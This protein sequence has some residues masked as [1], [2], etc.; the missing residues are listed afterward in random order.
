[1]KNKTTHFWMHLAGVLYG[2]LLSAQLQA[3]DILALRLNV[4]FY[5]TP[6]A[7][8]LDEISEKGRFQWSYN[9]NILEKDRRVTFASQQQTVREIL[10]E[11]LGGE[12][13]FKQSGE[14]LI[15]KKVKKPE[16]R[17]SGYLSDKKTGKKLPNATIYDRQTLKSTTTDEH[18][19]YELPVTPRSE[20]VV[21]TLDYKD[22]VLQVTS[23]SPRFLKIEMLPDSSGTGDTPKSLRNTVKEDFAKMQRDFT[24]LFNLSKQE[25]NERNTNNDSLRRSF[26]LSFMPHLGTNHRMS[27]SVEND[28][29]INI[30]VGYSKGNRLVEVGGIGNITRENI[31]GVQ[32]GGVFNAVG[33]QV[34]GVQIGGTFNAVDGH[35]DGVQIG[36]TFNVVDGHVDGVQIGGTLNAVDGNVTGVQIGGVLN[37]V[38][39]NVDGVQI[40]G[41]VNVVEGNALGVQIA[42]CHNQADTAAL[43]ISGI[44]NISQYQKGPQV[45]GILNITEQADNAIQ[46]GGIL[47]IS[48]RGQTPTQVG[49][50]GNIADTTTGTQVA[51]IFNRANYVKGVQVG[52]INSARTI[53]GVQVGLLNF[54]RYGGYCTLEA[55]TNEIHWANVALKTGTHRFYTIFTAGYS[56]ETN[57]A[58]KE[59]LWSYGAGIGTYLRAQKRFGVSFDL[60]HRHLS[61]G[62]YSDDLREW[63]QLAVGFNWRLGKHFHLAAGPS[64]NLLITRDQNF[65]NE[66]IPA[67]YPQGNPTNSDLL[68]FWAGG[69]VSV[70]YRF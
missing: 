54:S 13:T 44:S 38:D 3:H 24:K 50:I 34:N 2:T 26:Q 37:A 56:P 42:G 7:T 59:T 22:T 1:M 25:I 16:Q 67:G 18:G 52:L 45:G 14:Y 4:S 63:E 55:S 30:L 69:T 62:R 60:I 19:Y 17:V 33:G 12:Y 53:N 28:I 40:G 21:A 39:G 31:E 61:Q 46:V 10:H 29:S 8:A 41:V 64:A 5:Q 27:G 65:K 51:G 47:N 35:V 57:T 68:R 11:I 49:G 9:A 58:E 32:I 15:L 66:L 48:E 20:I 43:Q 70:K 6:I 36:G 23:Q